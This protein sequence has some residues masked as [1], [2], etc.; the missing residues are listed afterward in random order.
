MLEFIVFCT[1]LCIDFNDAK[2]LSK[3]CKLCH[4]KMTNAYFGF[5]KNLD[6]ILTVYA[7]FA[8]LYKTFSH[9][10]VHCKT[11]T[12]SILKLIQN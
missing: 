12:C 5:K 1:S 9:C 8:I 7:S 10:A 11:A 2:H 3:V 4:F 6:S